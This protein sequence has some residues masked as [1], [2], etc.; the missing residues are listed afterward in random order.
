MFSRWSPQAS[1][2]PQA[3]SC[4]VVPLAS[5]VRRWPRPYR[6]LLAS[7]G[8]THQASRS[9]IS[10]RPSYEEESDAYRGVGGE[11]LGTAGTTYYHRQFETTYNQQTVL[12]PTVVNQFQ[13]LAGHELEPLTS[14]SPLRG[15]VVSGAFTGGG[16]Q[17]DVRRTE[18]HVQL[19]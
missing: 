14:V 10:I 6:H 3:A 5:T 1:R 9:T 16:A 18:A 19:S 8:I 17:V 7:V 2:S 12:G 15:I 13:V 11:T 4:S